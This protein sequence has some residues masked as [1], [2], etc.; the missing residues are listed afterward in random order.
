[1]KHSSILPDFD[2][3]YKFLNDKVLRIKDNDIFF[4]NKFVLDN[5]DF[6]SFP[7]AIQKHQAYKHG[8]IIHT[9]QVLSTTLS[10]LYS[11]YEFTDHDYNVAVTAVLWHDFAKIYDYKDVSTSTSFK[12]TKTPHYD[13]QRHL[14]RSYADFR[15]EASKYPSINQ[16]FVDDVSHCILAHHG[17]LEWGSPVEPQNL[18]AFAIHAYDMV[19]SKYLL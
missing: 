1:M 19:S 13:D 15:L 4:L 7:A 18:I 3:S 5:G 10:I 9:A 17:R 2:T 11:A 16:K 12:Y 8:L 14:V 6:L